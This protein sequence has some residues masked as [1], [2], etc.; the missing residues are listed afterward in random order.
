MVHKLQRFARLDRLPFVE[1]RADHGQPFPN[2]VMEELPTIL[3]LQHIGQSSGST[4]LSAEGFREM[5]STHLDILL[6]AL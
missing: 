2:L 5:G 4:C 6:E 3:D 1:S